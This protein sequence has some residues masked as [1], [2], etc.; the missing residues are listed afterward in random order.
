M[1]RAFIASV[2]TF[3]NG[4]H[5]DIGVS[6]ALAADSIGSDDGLRPEQPVDAEQ[7][8]RQIAQ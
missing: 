2:V 8:G 7:V 6:L 4:V 3:A 1:S 5:I